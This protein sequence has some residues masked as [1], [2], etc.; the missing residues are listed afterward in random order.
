MACLPLCT[1][2]MLSLCPLWF[3]FG[4]RNADL[5]MRCLVHDNFQG[6]TH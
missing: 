2:W 5:C 3:D 6:Y 4:M 1:L